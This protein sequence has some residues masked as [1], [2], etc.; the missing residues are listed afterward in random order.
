MAKHPQNSN[1]GIFSKSAIMVGSTG[2]FATNYSE[3]TA[4][5]TFD[6]T[7]VPTVAVGTIK[8]GAMSLA[9][10]STGLTIG[11]AQISTS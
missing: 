7:G 4:A 8:I 2:I 6:S 1:R 5:F 9:A 3:N 11:G 10:N